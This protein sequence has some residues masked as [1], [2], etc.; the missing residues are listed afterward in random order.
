MVT[1]A[2]AARL[3]SDCRYVASDLNQPM[4]YHAAKVQARVPLGARPVL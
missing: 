3:S 1:G 2:M 4:L